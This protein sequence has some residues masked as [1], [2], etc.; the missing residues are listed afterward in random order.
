MNLMPL[1]VFQRLGL[2]ELKPTH[3]SLHMANRSVAHPRGIVEDVLIKVDKFFYLVDF[4][5]LDMHEDKEIPLIL[6]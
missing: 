5:V 2:G 4:V 6:G 3:V 1:S